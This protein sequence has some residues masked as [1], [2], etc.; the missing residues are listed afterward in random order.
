MKELWG[1]EG[2]SRWDRLI[3]D[4]SFGYMLEWLMLIFPSTHIPLQYLSLDLFPILFL[5]L[6]CCPEALL[7]H[8]LPERPWELN[9]LNLKYHFFFPNFKS[10]S[11]HLAKLYQRLVFQMSV[12]TILLC[13]SRMSIHYQYG[14]RYHANSKNQC[15]CLTLLVLVYSRMGSFHCS[16][17]HVC[18]MIWVDEVLSMSHWFDLFHVFQAR[19]H[20]ETKH[21]FSCRDSHFPG[22]SK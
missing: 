12:F 9:E 13:F 16:F 10:V 5:E 17:I 6:A 8:I 1:S 22:L 15:D 7:P 21:A 11:Y 4:G 18:C 19:P 20:A 3:L 2:C 14:S